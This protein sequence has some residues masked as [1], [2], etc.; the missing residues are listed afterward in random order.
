M[1]LEYSEHNMLPFQKIV[2]MCDVDEDFEYIN[3]SL[4]MDF[5]E[6]GGAQSMRLIASFASQTARLSLRSSAS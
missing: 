3:Q 1:Y 6:G 2:T 4:V 5:D